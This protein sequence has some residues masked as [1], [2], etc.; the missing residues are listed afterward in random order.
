MKVSKRL[1]KSF[2]LVALAIGCKPNAGEET[3]SQLGSIGN[4]E[5]P[6]CV[7]GVYHVNPGSSEK[8]ANSKVVGGTLIYEA[9]F[10]IN[11]TDPQP[12][13]I[14]KRHEESGNRMIL[15]KFKLLDSIPKQ[16]GFGWYKVTPL[17]GA[18]A[19]KRTG[20]IKANELITSCKDFTNS[21]FSNPA[22]NINISKEPENEPGK[23]DMYNPPEQV[24]CGGNIYNLI[25]VDIKN[26]Q[27]IIESKPS[28]QSRFFSNSEKV[29]TRKLGISY[30]LHVC[31]EVE[32]K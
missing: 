13:I 12:S 3:Q 22:T 31:R 5:F 21:T 24:D 9:H 20:Y 8:P 26:A 4:A 1:L 17:T 7:P 19:N 25:K 30:C 11:R 16:G 2:V 28:W 18:F 6:D 27:C 14:Y 15:N 10:Y 23:L 32:E 29:K